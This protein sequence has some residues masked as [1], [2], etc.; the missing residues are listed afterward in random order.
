MAQNTFLFNCFEVLLEK[1][2]TAHVAMKLS[3]AYGSLAEVY[4]KFYFPPNSAT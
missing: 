1:L 2:T 3:A 4:G